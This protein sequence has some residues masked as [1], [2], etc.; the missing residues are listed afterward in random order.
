MIGAPQSPPYT[1]NLLL[2][3]LSIVGAI[4]D[5]RYKAQG[6]RRE[7]KNWWRVFLTFLGFVA[8][9]FVYLGYQGTS[10]GAFGSLTGNLVVW[11]FAG[12]ELRRFFIR[13]S[14]PIAPYKK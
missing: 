9:L 7:D 3:V 1:G 8:I 14:N 13:R 5:G 6:G 12:Y 4:I 2:L 10:A 11:T